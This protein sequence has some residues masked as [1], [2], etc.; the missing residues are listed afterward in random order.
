MADATWVLASRVP[1]SAMHGDLELQ[2]NIMSR[3]FD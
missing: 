3:S 2:Y 1:K